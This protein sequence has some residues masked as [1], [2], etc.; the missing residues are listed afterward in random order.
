MRQANWHGVKGMR[1]PYSEGIT[2]HTGPESCVSVGNDRCEALT[3]EHAGE[4]L[5]CEITLSRRPTL[6]SRAEGNIGS[7]VIREMLSAPAQSETLCTRGDSKPGPGRS[8]RFPE[9]EHRDG[10][11]GEGDEP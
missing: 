2:D 7:I 10:T 1:K 9:R 11:V 8:C 3:G 5:S 6:S 4:P